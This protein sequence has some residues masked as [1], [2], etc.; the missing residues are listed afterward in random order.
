MRERLDEPM[1]LHDMA[2]IAYISPYHFNRVFH[3]ITGVPPIKFLSAMRLDAAKKLLLTTSLSVTDVCFELGYNSLGTFTSRFTELVGLSPCQFRHLAV[4]MSSASLERL[5]A[6]YEEGLEHP[7]TNACITG[8]VDAPVAIE[9]L[10]FVGLFRA[11]IAQS[12]PVGGTLLFEPG[13][14][15]IRQVPDGNYY[16][17]A[18]ALPGLIDPASYLLPDHKMLLVGAGREQVLVRGGR[19]YSDTNLTLRPMEVTDPP[20]LISL[21]YLLTR[22]GSQA[23]FRNVLKGE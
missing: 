13:T 23:H 2:G 7:A 1:S 4:Q 19:A 22:A 20:L 11:Q 10:I 5:R 21:P 8:R 16:L 12:Y 6:H 18:A 15:R 9:G 17:L 14:Y 3:Q